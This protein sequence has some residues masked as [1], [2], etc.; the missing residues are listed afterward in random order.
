MHAPELLPIDL[1]VILVVHPVAAE[2]AR[3]WPSTPGYAVEHVTDG[4]DVVARC[5]ASGIQVVFAFA[6]LTSPSLF[7]RLRAARPTLGRVLIVAGGPLEE[8]LRQVNENACHQVLLGS[9]ERPIVSGAIA[10]A[11]D[12]ARAATA[13][14][15][16]APGSLGARSLSAQSLSRRR[17]LALLSE[18]ER[19]ILLHLAKGARIGD[20]SGALH[21]SAHTVRNHIKAMFRKL[22]VH[23]QS[24]LVA[25]AR[26]K[27][28]RPGPG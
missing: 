22:D 21:L 20:I 18:R 11:F 10:D 17:Q 26:T 28:L 19:E 27:S 7:K 15:L 25:L 16:A 23:S 5:D 6:S 2:H 12:G 4:E 8:V 24:E 9:L 1:R 13:E 3:A 14:A